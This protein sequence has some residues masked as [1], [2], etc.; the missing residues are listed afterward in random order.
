[1]VVAP[2]LAS[3]VPEAAPILIEQDLVVSWPS[4]E[5]LL[6]NRLAANGGQSP[7]ESSD[8]RLRRTLSAGTEMID[9]A[10]TPDKNGSR[11]SATNSPDKPVDLCLKENYACLDFRVGLSSRA[12]PAFRPWR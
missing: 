6:D 2:G 1:M 9:K 4:L 12:R 7:A 11:W 8:G 10:A 5:I 3:Q